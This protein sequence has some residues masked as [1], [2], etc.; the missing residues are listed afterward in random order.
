MKSEVFPNRMTEF[1]VFGPKFYCYKIYDRQSD[2]EK[3]V[4]KSK[5]INQKLKTTNDETI[6]SLINDARQKFFFET[7]Q[8]NLRAEIYQ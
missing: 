6:N 7:F 3:Q 8:K 5:G 4:Y 1:K 2:K